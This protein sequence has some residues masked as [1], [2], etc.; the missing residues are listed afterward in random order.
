MVHILPKYF[1]VTI[2]I[3]GICAIIHRLIKDKNLS[4]YKYNKLFYILGF[5]ICL[6]AADSLTLKIFYDLPLLTKYI[7]P[8]LILFFTV[9]LYYKNY[10][11]KDYQSRPLKNKILEILEFLFV[12][13]FLMFLLFR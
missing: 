7:I 10:K 11:E 3:V 12:I 5:L 13:I 9:V 2:I 8:S 6:F 1:W 4:K